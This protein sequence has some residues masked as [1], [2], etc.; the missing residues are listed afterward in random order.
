MVN[1]KLGTYIMEKTI[2]IDQNR[3][4]PKFNRPTFRNW[5]KNYES[6]KSEK[7]VAYFVG[8]F[9]DYNSPSTGKALVKVLEMNGIEVVIPEQDCCGITRNELWKLGSCS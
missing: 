3:H 8:C 2:G 9:A 5:F 1:N 7:K 4:L 6:I